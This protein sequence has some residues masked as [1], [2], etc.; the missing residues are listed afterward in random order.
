MDQFGVLVESIGFKAQGRS[1]PLAD[2]KG[3]TTPTTTAPADRF[4]PS[5]KS[6][7]F[8]SS[9]VNGSSFVDDLDGIFRSNS[10]NHR[11]SQ[12]APATDFDDIFGDPNVNFKP[13]SGGSMFDLDS[14]F[15][16]S[17]NLGS[18]L[19]DDDIFGGMPGLKSYGSNNFDDMLFGGVPKNGDSVNDLL[20]NFGGIG[21]KSNGS[22]RNNS[23]KKQLDNG[24][25]SDDLIPGFGGSSPSSNGAKSETRPSQQSNHPAAKSFSTSAEDPFVILERTQG[26][27]GGESR[28]SEYNDLDSFFSPGKQSR[29][30]PSQRS[31]TEDSV[32]DALFQNTKGSKVEPISSANSY[33]KKNTS[34]A[35]ST[36]D[37]FSFL[38]GMG[39]A[40]P[41]SGEF[42]EVEGE[43]E[44]RRRARLK[45]HIKTQ[46]RMAKVLNEKNQRDLQSQREQE[47]RHRLAETLDV[48]IKRWAAGKEGNLRALLSSLQYVLWHECGWQP[49][50]LTDLITSTSVKKVY[51]KATLC[52]HPDKVQQKGANLQEK[53]TAEKVF[54]IL[55]EAWNK[56]NSEELKKR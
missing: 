33:S 34:P 36:A 22:N 3:K 51:Y 55:K 1:T 12:N 19:D 38:F 31:T 4:P 14:V 46:E 54:D 30:A 8:N 6:S 13:S 44:E 29:A 24:L 48:D 37:D 11:K 50:S 49:V 53:Y 26:R 40:A 5:T 56:F 20:G 23:E 9:F 18:R 43:S 7:S 2:L 17:S 21:L 52:V 28:A 27:A 35:K 41:S 10:T 42:K 25:K 45:H 32:Y 47:E 39:E 15:K 16:G